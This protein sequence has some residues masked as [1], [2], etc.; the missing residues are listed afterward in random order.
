MPAQISSVGRVDALDGLRTVAVAAVVVSHAAGP[1]MPGGHVGVD[2]FFTLSGFVI[3]LLLLREFNATGR[4]SLRAFYLH[5][6]ARLWPAMLAVC[7]IVVVLA[8]VAP[9][10]WGEQGWNAVL[11]ASHTM[12]LWRGGWFGSSVDGGALGHTWSLAVEEQFYLVW[13]LILVVLLRKLTLRAVSAVTA[14]LVVLALVER[15]ALAF[16]GVSPWRLAN[17]PDTRADQ[18]LIGC[19]LAM[20]LTLAPGS[21]IHEWSIRLAWP[22]GLVLVTA[23]FLLVPH[24][25]PGP[26]DVAMRAFS[27]ILIAATSAVLISGL[28][29]ASGQGLSLLLAHKALAWTGRNLSYGIYLW[30]YPILFGVREVIEFPGAEILRAA[31]SVAL[32]I[33]VAYLS[34]RYIE[35]PIRSAAKRA[36]VAPAK[37]PRHRAAHS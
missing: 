13:P 20:L 31:L 2:V 11:S 36:T 1:L 8:L 9:N 17:G 12:N 3:T 6:L 4:V 27:P 23:A 30:H 29:C 21:R 33:A 35:A 32:T 10:E 26:L 7:A 15:A 34:A 16:S 24:D 5:R 25:G 37:R 19:L 22:A 14:V 18:L 28:V